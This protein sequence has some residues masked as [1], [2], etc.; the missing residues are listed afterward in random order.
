MNKA[1]RSQSNYHG[2][3]AAESIVMRDYE[4]RGFRIAGQRWRGKG[5]EIDLIFRDGDCVVF[6]EVKKSRTHDMAIQRLSRRQ[7]D[8]ICAAASEFIGNEPRGLLTEMRFDVATVDQTG[9]VR[10]IENAFVTA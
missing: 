2:G 3:I 10:I 6:T 5:G 4:R 1:A 7:M 8:R 9:T